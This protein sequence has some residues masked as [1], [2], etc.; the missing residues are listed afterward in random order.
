MSAPNHLSGLPRRRVLQSAVALAAF[1]T[2]RSFAAASDLLGST[3]LPSALI[4]LDLPAIAENGAVVPVTVTSALPGTRE[5]VLL[6]EHNPEPVALRV[7]IPVGTEPYVATR[8][9]MAAS[10]TV[11][12]AVRTDDGLYA[13][14]RAVEVVVGGCG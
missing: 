11:H 6:V 1:G 3:P 8:I 10:G 9:R 7:T 12:A 14:S 2:S 5:I 13:A 4:T